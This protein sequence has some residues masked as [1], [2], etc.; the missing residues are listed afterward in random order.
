MNI[1]EL[2][3]ILTNKI[4]FLTTQKNSASSVGDLNEVL[5]L[6]EEIKEIEKVISKLRS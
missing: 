2:I 1:D 6:E 4:N 3:T 5:K